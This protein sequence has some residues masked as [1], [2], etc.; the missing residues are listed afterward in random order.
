MAPSP[1][2]GSSWPCCCSTSWSG[3]TPPPRS[4]ADSA[5]DFFAL[6]GL[7]DRLGAGAGVELFGRV[8]D[9]GAHRLRREDQ[10]P[11][12]LLAGQPVSEEAENLRLPGAQRLRRSP[13]AVLLDEAAVEVA[14]AAPDLAQ[15]L[16]Q[17]GEP[18]R[19]GDK[20]E[21]SAAVGGL[22]QVGVAE[23]GVDDELR[24]RRALAHPPHQL[25][26]ALVGE[27]DAD[28]GD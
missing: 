9:V 12:D 13:V 24:A 27:V 22:E 23:A 17:G 10:A 8:A 28:H 2:P 16:D 25:G 14:A 21:R 18:R 20:A 5:A 6:Q 3:S 19:L 1:S 11:G 26:A 4:P 15:R 7:D